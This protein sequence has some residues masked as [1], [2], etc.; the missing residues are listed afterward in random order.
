MTQL[1]G[2]GQ[3]V[4]SMSAKPWP[5]GNLSWGLWFWMVL[6]IEASKKSQSL[7]QTDSSLKLYVGFPS[8][9]RPGVR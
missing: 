1:L 6:G 3:E 2:I 5:S 9:P 8:Q 7:S 4:L